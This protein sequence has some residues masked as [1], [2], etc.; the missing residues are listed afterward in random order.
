M[1]ETLMTMLRTLEDVG[2]VIM[3]VEADGSLDLTFDDFEGFDEEWNEMDRPYEM[4]ELVDEVF[5]LLQSCESEGDYYVTYFVDGHEVCVGF[6]S[7]DI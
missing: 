6:T 2:D 1:F 5:D 3:T 7:Y 4:P